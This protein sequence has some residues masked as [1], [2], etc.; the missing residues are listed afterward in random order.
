MELLQFVETYPEGEGLYPSLFD[1]F[2]KV[3]RKAASAGKTTAFLPHMGT[4]AQ[5]AFKDSDSSF[6]LIPGPYLTAG[7]GPDP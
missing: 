6:P 7:I 2:L 3:S 5:M 1:W 4:I